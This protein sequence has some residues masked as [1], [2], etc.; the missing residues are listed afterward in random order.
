VWAPVFFCISN[1]ADSSIEAGSHHELGMA[2]NSYESGGEPMVLKRLIVAVA[3]YHYKG[4]YD[5]VVTG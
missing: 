5:S 1:R 2:H 3:K 4:W